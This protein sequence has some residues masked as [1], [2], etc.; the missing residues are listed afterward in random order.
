VHKYFV[1]PQ[2]NSVLA[3]QLT[4]TH[5]TQQAGFQSDIWLA[6]GRISARYSRCLSRNE[7]GPA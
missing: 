7:G 2:Y 5:D 1:K 3:S 4:R 6:E